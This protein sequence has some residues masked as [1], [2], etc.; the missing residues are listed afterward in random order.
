MSLYYSLKFQNLPLNPLPHLRPSCSISGDPTGRSLS[1]ETARTLHL[2][3]FDQT[4][5]LRTSDWRHFRTSDRTLHLRTS[6]DRPPLKTLARDTTKDEARHEPTEFTVWS[7]AQ[8]CSS[9][10]ARVSNALVGDRQP[11]GAAAFVTSN[12]AYNPFFPLSLRAQ[13]ADPLLDLLSSFGLP[14][15]LISFFAKISFPS[16]LPFS[17][18]LPSSPLLMAQMLVPISGHGFI[19]LSSLLASLV[20]IIRC[21]ILFVVK[22]RSL[23]P[24]P[25]SHLDSA[26][27]T[28]RGLLLLGCALQLL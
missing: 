19:I 1:E 13:S 14:I 21:S 28:S 6:T 22:Q 26:S 24:L 8:V 10:S 16:A 11:H 4:I 25:S 18:W 7:G 12:R 27:L 15:P 9:P 20:L 23:E 17:L 2:T 5:H 3:T